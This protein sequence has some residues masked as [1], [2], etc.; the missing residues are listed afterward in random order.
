MRNGF[1]LTRIKSLQENV[2]D[3][4]QV[5]LFIEFLRKKYS[6]SYKNHGFVF[7][8]HIEN[9]TCHFSFIDEE[10]ISLRGG[11]VYPKKKLYVLSQ[12]LNSMQ[13]ISIPN[14]NL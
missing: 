6:K 5:D 2:S 11:S 14:G 12:I 13:V 3:L 4:K 1:L 10:F 9:V 7:W 8:C